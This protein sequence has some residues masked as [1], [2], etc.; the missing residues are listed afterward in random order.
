MSDGTETRI[1][2]EMAVT[3]DELRRGFARLEPDVTGA[4]RTLGGDRFHFPWAGGE[5][6]VSLGPETD[7]RL[8]M[9]RI[10]C[11]SVTLTFRNLSQGDISDF[12]SRFDRRFQRGGG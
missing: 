11:T 10:P 8:G 7:R 1:T 5:A 9:L 2:K 6:E 3:H 4:W 12:I